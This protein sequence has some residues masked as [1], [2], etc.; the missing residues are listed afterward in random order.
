L[1]DQ[2]LIKGTAPDVHVAYD[3]ATNRRTSDIADANGNLVMSNNSSHYVY[4]GENRLIRLGTYATVNYAYDASNHRVWRNDTVAGVDELAFWGGGQKLGTYQMSVSGSTI[5]F[6]LQATNV[7]FGGKLIAKGSYLSMGGDYVNLTPVVADRLGSIGK[8]YPYGTERPSATQNDTEKFT[9]YFRD[10]STGLDYA[11]QRYHQPGTGRFMTPDPYAGSANPNDPGS[12]NRYAYVGGD[13]TNQT[14]PKGLC[15]VVIGG[16]TD[17]PG[18]DTGESDFA[19]SIGANEAYP[20]AGSDKITGLAGV[21]ASSLTQS[22]QAKAVADAIMGAAADSSG[23]INVFAFSG[24]AAAFASALDLLPKNVIA[25]IQ[26]V[27]Y[28]SPGIVGDLPAVNGNAPT[29]ILGDG[30]R[31]D[32]ATALTGLPLG[33]TIIE[34]DCG[35]NAGCLFMH[36]ASQAGNACRNPAAPVTF[37]MKGFLGTYWDIMNGIAAAAQAAYQAVWGGLGLSS[38][39]IPTWLT[40]SAPSI[41]F[42]SSTIKFQ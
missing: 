27:T 42:V 34:T 39:Q 19:D 35:H 28:A 4:D 37:D 24:G 9:G 17:G 12:W 33:T 40:G 14:D 1:T 22:Y 31:D 20:Y 36:A 23:P 10:G 18:N 38:I 29:V 30:F 26:N 13:P 21:I 16:I 32:I 41:P 25:R 7:Y 5:Y 3:P 15:D 11:D 8:F 6:N 2:T